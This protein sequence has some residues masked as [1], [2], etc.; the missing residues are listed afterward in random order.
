MNRGAADSEGHTTWT[1]K[2]EQDDYISFA[3]FMIYYLQR[4]RRQEDDPY[5]LETIQSVSNSNDAQLAGSAR[6]PISLLLAGYS[7]GSLVLARLPPVN[8]IVAIFESAAI[9]TSGAEIILRGGVLGKQTVDSWLTSQSPSSPRGRQLKPD[10][11]ATSPQRRV[12]ASPMTVGG[13]ETD[14]ASRRRSRDSRRSG[15]FVRRSMEAPQR[16]KARVTGANSAAKALSRVDIAPPQPPSMNVPC[17]PTVRPSYLVISPVL[18]PFS[19][20]LC[21]PGPPSLMPGLRRHS[22]AD[23]DAGGAFHVN[24]TLALFGSSDTFTS[25]RRLKTWAEKNMKE[26]KASFEWTQIDGAGH[27]WSEDGVMQALQKRIAEWVSR[28]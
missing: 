10:D 13:E 14:P 17:G 28:S 4:L 11:T 19:H 8:R 6:P 3:G 5:R 21:P 24:D 26:S 23:S 20:T 7:Y 15:D 22:S 2:A 9:G 25:S 12:G 16:I 18:L 1:G 27:F